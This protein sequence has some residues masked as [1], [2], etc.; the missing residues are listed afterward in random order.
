MAIFKRFDNGELIDEYN[1]IEDVITD[2]NRFYYEQFSNQPDYDDNFEV[3]TTKQAIDL[4]EANGYEVQV[5][6]TQG[7]CPVCG[8]QNITYNGSDIESYSYWYKCDCDD[9]NAYFEETYS[10]E[11]VGFDNIQK[12][13]E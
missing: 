1:T 3:K 11:F 7:H 12:Y 10:L 5:V 9:C 13:E 4:F 2:A 6:Q 8:S